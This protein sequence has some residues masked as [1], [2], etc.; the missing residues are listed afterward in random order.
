MDTRPIR[1]NTIYNRISH[2]GGG[3]VSENAAYYYEAATKAIEENQFNKRSHILTFLKE[4]QTKHAA[5]KYSGKCINMM[6]SLYRRNEF[7]LLE[8]AVKIFNKEIFPYIENPTSVVE[9]ASIRNIGEPNLDIFKETSDILIRCDRIISNDKKLSKR[10][11]INEYV[12]D[13][14]RVPLEE[15]VYGVCN[16]IDTYN[17]TPIAKMNIALEQLPYML[18]KAGVT[19]E[20]DILVESIVE[21]FLSRDN[22]TQAIISTG[23]TSILK[24]NKCLNTNALSRVSYLIESEYLADRSDIQAVID[25]YK[26]DADKSE[27]KFQHAMRTIFS[28]KPEDIIDDIPSIISLIRNFLVLTTYA[29]HPVFG[30]LVTLVNTITSYDIKRKDAERVINTFKTEQKRIEDRIDRTTNDDTRERLEEYLDALEASIQKLESYRDELYTDDEL[31]RQSELEDMDEGAE[32]IRLQEF[33]VFKF[34][35]LINLTLDA[36]NYISTKAK[37]IKNKV[38][39]KL[40]KKKDTIEESSIFTY[41]TESGLLDLCVASFDT[42]EVTNINKLHETMS[43]L[44]DVLNTRSNSEE[45]FYY[46]VNSE[47][48]EIRVGC[49]RYS[50]FLSE[51]VDMLAEH[52]MADIDIY[53]TAELLYCEKAVEDLASIYEKNLLEASKDMLLCMKDISR[54]KILIEALYISGMYNEE[55]IDSIVKEYTTCLSESGDPVNPYSID[56]MYKDLKLCN[57]NRIMCYDLYNE[58]AELIIDILDEAVNLNSIKLAMEGIKKKVKDLS[59]K[60]KEMSRDLDATVNSLVRGVKSALISDRREGI[61]KGSIVP[62]FSKTLKIGIGLAA[63]AIPLHQPIL[64]AIALIGGLAMSKNLTNKERSLLLDEIDIEL[65]VVD[66]EIKKVED[67]GKSTRKYRTLLAYQKNLQREKQ[68]I[69]YN[70]GMAGKKLPP[71]SMGIKGGG[72]D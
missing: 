46:T 47:S 70:L 54:E 5:N 28:R 22:N 12:L 52:T 50:I 1:M 56:I 4:C 58:S 8:E 21:Y 15:T 53:K 62:S 48:C 63:I 67:N 9:Y 61:I 71:S 16:M 65:Q 19:F 42:T 24:E 51:D 45:M 72:E 49:A 68:R 3:I 40:T 14:R 23:Y 43:S 2:L 20:D 29:I 33:K 57:T 36:S 38:K 69:K 10:F 55:D 39:A 32:M 17:T 18:E 26:T 7:N 66:R 25:K 27:T 6:S 13:R 41:V 30:V 60:E 35:N 11:N 31:E 59:S 64:A 37:E 34:Q 44:C